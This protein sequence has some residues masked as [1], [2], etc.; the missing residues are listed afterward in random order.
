MC[1]IK[2]IVME[3]NI[4]VTDSIAKGKAKFYFYFFGGTGVWIHSLVLAR[5]VPYHLGEAKFY[6]LDLFEWQVV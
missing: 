4:W 2:N 6:K 1:I 3:P 5:L